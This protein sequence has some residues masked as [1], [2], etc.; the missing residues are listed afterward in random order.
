MSRKIPVVALLLGAL[1]LACNE[2]TGPAFESDAMQTAVVPD[3]ALNHLKWAESD[4]PREFTAVGGTERDSE[5][6]L[7]TVG[8]GGY[9]E[10]TTYQVSFWA[11]KG[12]DR[13][14]QINYITK[15]EAGYLVAPY[16]LFEVPAGAL[17]E[18]PN[19]EEYETG[20]SVKITITVDPQTMVAHYSPSGLQFDENDPALLTKWYTGA[21]DDFNDDGVVDATDA[22]IEANLLGIWTQQSAG[23]PWYKLSALHSMAER[24]FKADIKHFSGYAV[25]WME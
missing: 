20:D 7:S 3:G 19:E 13:S 10:L 15:T 4:S 17:D 24:W 22:Y 12:E 25:S 18:G 16:L 23:D 11:V 1:A 6:L 21:D 9:W 14:V 8:G 2:G 5:I